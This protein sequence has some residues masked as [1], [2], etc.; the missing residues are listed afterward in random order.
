MNDQTFALTAQSEAVLLAGFILNDDGVQVH[1]PDFDLSYVTDQMLLEE[2]KAGLSTLTD[3]GLANSVRKYRNYLALAKAY[4]GVPLMPCLDIDE[5]W[6]NHVL[7]T[8]RYHEDCMGYFGYMLH[9]NP[10]MPTQEVAQRS[11]E[12]YVKHFGREIG[13]ENRCIVMCCCTDT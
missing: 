3:E 13:Y 1:L 4:P 8:R 2:K 9:H 10:A 12:L 7:N 11:G 6:H 5:V